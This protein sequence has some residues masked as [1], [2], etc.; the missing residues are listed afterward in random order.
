MQAHRS[1]G[2]D[3]GNHRNTKAQEEE[4]PTDMRTH[5]A[6][7]KEINAETKDGNKGLSDK[8]R[9]CTRQN[10]RMRN[11]DWK[12]KTNE[13]EKGEK[14]RHRFTQMSK[15]SEEIQVGR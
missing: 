4:Q 14:T 3:G 12:I 7:I 13:L 11:K 6:T 8:T 15:S 2:T 9:T 5:A 1:S 10:R